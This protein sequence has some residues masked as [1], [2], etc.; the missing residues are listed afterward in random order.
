M[1]PDLLLWGGQ[2]EADELYTDCISMVQLEGDKVMA[3]AACRSDSQ[4]D[5]DGRMHTFA[6]A[7]SSDGIRV[8]A[9][10]RAG[11]ETVRA[12]CPSLAAPLICFGKER[13]SFI[14]QDS[15]VPAR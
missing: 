14:S 1:G 5:Q 7:T 6:A 4:L 9:L 13:R 2:G 10:V 15:S 8:A 11:E 12:S 3:V